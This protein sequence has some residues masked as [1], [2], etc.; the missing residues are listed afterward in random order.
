MVRLAIFAV[1]TMFGVIGTLAAQHRK[2]IGTTVAKANG[3]LDC[4]SNGYH[5]AKSY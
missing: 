2:S 5:G 4:V 3:A 1:G